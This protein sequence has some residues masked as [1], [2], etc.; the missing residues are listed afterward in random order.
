[1]AKYK[2]HAKYNV[3]CMRVSEEEKLT[4]E[5]LMKKSSM[6]ISGLMREAIQLYTPQLETRIQK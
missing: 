4:L 2:V 3:V 1:M 5:E 6:T